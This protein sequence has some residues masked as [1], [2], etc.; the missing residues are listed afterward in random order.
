MPDRTLTV[1]Y[2]TRTGLLEPLGQS[3][4]FAYLRALA[5]E[6]RI[7][8]VTCEKHSDR[9]DGER[10]A[11]ADEAC[12]L[13]GIDW[14]PVPFELGPGPVSTYR[15]H[16][17]FVQEVRRES[18]QGPL[19]VHARS[20][21]PVAAALASHRRSGTPFVFDM[22]ALWP[23][24]LIMAGRLRR[25]SIKHRILQRLE[26]KALQHGEVV[27]LTHAAAEHLKERF[28]AELKDKE[29]HVI[30]TCTDL[31]RF[32][33]APM[34]GGPLV[35]GCFGTVLSGWFRMDLLAAWF[36]TVNRH[37]PDAVTEVVTKDDRALVEQAL[38][39]LGVRLESLRIRSAA[40]NQMP[41]I[42]RAQTVSGMFFKTGLGKL[43]SCPTRLGEVLGSGRPVVSNGG[44]GDVDRVINDSRV[45]VLV[46]STCVAEQDR[47]MA[48]L[49]AL[50]SDPELSARCRATAE[51]RFSLESGVAKYRSIYN[52]M[53][54]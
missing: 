54:D 10:M 24:E 43:G 21:L 9:A 41:E 11:A 25:D 32:R 26:R 40:P 29:I 51:Q 27:S 47:A 2:L 45:G 17:R 37:F 39:E 48:R 1:V 46:D 8:L 42:V 13:A 50:L 35:F 15:H 14:R 5:T 33:P 49:Q 23:E 36:C 12:R 16:R 22:R 7:V 19:V 3:Q 52:K 6:F 44:I 18:K 28:P 34:P 30:P 38:V 20:Y 4:V 31:E 53:A